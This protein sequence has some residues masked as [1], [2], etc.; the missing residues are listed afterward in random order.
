LVAP[1]GPHPLERLTSLFVIEVEAG[2]VEEQS[3]AVAFGYQSPRFVTARA[4]AEKAAR[5]AA[6]WLQSRAD[7]AAHRAALVGPTGTVIL[8]WHRRRAAS[9]GRPR[10]S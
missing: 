6:Y 4:D 1:S 9:S 5:W 8:R 10:T 2:V 3:R 7:R